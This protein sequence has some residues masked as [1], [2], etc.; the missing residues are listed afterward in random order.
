M[1]FRYMHRVLWIVLACA[2]RLAAQGRADDT[3]AILT[4]ME[5]LAP[6]VGTWKA[7]AEFHQK[8]GLSTTTSAPTR[9][10]PVLEGTYLRSEVVLHRK[11][12][13]KKHHSFWILT[14]FNPQTGQY[15]Q[16]Y[17]YSGWALRVT[18][19]GEYDAAAHEFR[20]KALIPL[21]DG[22][23]D[24]NVRT[25]TKLAD[26]NKIVYLHYSRYNDEPASEWTSK[27]RSRGVH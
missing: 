11:E 4:N 16:T 26:I 1:C 27:S 5:H 20:T 3:S 15:D 23:R 2:L 17:F 9:S 14:T 25:V 10:A 12:D 18:E 13:P 7:V 24:E 6:L 21:E 22:K 19:T 8:D